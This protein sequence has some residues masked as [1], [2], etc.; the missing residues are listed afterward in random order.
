MNALLL[1]VLLLGHR[2]LIFALSVWLVLVGR[3][4]PSVVYVRARL[5]LERQEAV[6]SFWAFVLALLALVVS[7]L[8]AVGVD[9]PLLVVLVFVV[10]L[11]RTA[12]GLSRFRLPLKAKHVGML[13]LVYGLMLVLSFWAWR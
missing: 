1:P 6:R 10:L 13:E 11:V 4:I 8:L 5:R 7:V 12:L 3:S 9:L 2:G